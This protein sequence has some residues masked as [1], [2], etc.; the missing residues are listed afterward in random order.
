L[1]SNIQGVYAGGDSAYAPILDT[2]A[3]I[4]HWQ[5][6]HYHGHIAALNM[7]GKPTEIQ[8]V[9]FFWTMLFG[10]GI[11]YAGTV[12]SNS[13]TCVDQHCNVWQLLWSFHGV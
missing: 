8:T 11:R 10:K 9:P 5:L 13:S 2:A 1:E 4:G 12:F 6:A 3:C 7:V